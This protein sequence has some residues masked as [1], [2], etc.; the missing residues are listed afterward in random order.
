MSLRIRYIILIVLLH[1]VITVL[2]YELFQDDKWIFLF[3]ELMILISLYVSFKLLRTI[4]QPFRLIK[5][6]KDTMLEEDF[7]IK[8][9]PT[10][11]KEM[12]DLIVVYNSMIERLRKE[13]TRTEE[14]SYFL[15][16]L[17]ENSPLGMLILDY[18]KEIVIANRQAKQFL[19]S[20]EL[21]GL[22]IDEIS[23]PLALAISEMASFE[24]KVIAIDGLRKYK[25]KVHQLV[26]K[27]FP[28]Q[29]VMIEEMTGE[30]LQAEKQAYGKVIRMMS[31]EVNNSMGAVNS[32]L[33]SVK[34]YGFPEEEESELEKYLGIAIERNKDLGRFTNNFAEFIRLPQPLLSKIDI[35]QLLNKQVD[36]MNLSAQKRMI[37]FDIRTFPE[38]I[39]ISADKIQLEQVISNIL[40]NAIESIDSDG[41][42]RVTTKPE[43]PQLTIA[44][45]GAGISE[46]VAEH[47]FSPFFSTKPT[48]QG[49]GLMLIRDILNNHKAEYRLYTDDDGWTKFE[50]GF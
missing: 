48:G 12:D 19:E 30:L 39:I 13:K 3:G 5:S 11:T 10:G 32:I 22:R 37:A 33:E 21:L 14:Q 18:E 40:K 16:D 20:D 49:I 50:I 47:I 1:T 6:G 46:D 36:Y 4:L 9:N 43:K 2:M 35:N 23:S 7:T 34:E 28:R 15:E 25:C 42:I 38:P 41:M 44:D 24:E 27:G 8:F 17:I 45:N 31:H 26:H 29:F